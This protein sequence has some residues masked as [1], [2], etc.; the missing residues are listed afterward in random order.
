MAY[1]ARWGPKGF[2]VSPSKV[3][4]FEEFFT[5]I[6]LKA[7]S[8]NDTS[9]TAPTNTRGRELQPMEFS[10][11]YMRAAG[12]DPREQIDEWESLVGKAYPLYIGNKRFGPSKMMLTKVEASDFLFS[13]KGD[14]LKVLIKIT[15]EEYSEGKSSKLAS[16]SS[17]SSSSKSKSKSSSAAKAS[18]TYQ[19]TVAKKEAEKKAA[20]NTTAS[21]STRA[22]LATEKELTLI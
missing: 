5:S 10:T 6:A 4:P 17:G 12:V 13:N 2:F 22:A 3:V 20:M 1:M 16:T 19:Q 11:T 14:F 21:K 9:G 8:E 7:D 15:L 18:S